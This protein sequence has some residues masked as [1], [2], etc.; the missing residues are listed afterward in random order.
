[1]EEKEKLNEETQVPAVVEQPDAATQVQAI[2]RQ[3]EMKIQQLME[4]MRQLDQMLRDKTIDQLF[5]VIKHASYFDPDFV[6]KSAKCIETYLTNLAFSSE[7][8]VQPEEK[9]E[10]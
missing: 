4:N 6:E 1:M 8:P 2:M 9:E 3:A 5:S 7:E 10:A